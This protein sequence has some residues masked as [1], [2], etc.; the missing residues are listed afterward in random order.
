[1]YSTKL[2]VHV[3]NKYANLLH[4]CEFCT[5]KSFIA[6]GSGLAIKFL[7]CFYN[8]HASLFQKLDETKVLLTLSLDLA[9]KYLTETS[10]KH[11]SLFQKSISY[12]RKSGGIFHKTLWICN[13]QKMNRFHSSQYLF[14]CQSLT[15]A[16]TKHTILLQNLHIMYLNVL[17]YRLQG[18]VL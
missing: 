1:V 16:W 8:K 15:Q 9:I 11:C 18:H 14:Y 13:L 12:I 5:E 7:L 2:L 6:L 17:Q 10:N 4:E 3:C